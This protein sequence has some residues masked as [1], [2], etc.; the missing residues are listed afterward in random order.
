MPTSDPQGTSAVLNVFLAAGGGTIL[1]LAG[2]FLT[3]LLRGTVPQEKE[4][5]D[6]MATEVKELR[7]EVRTLRSEVS[8]MSGRIEQ[9]IRL[10]AR[11]Y[12]QRE[13]ARLRVNLLEQKYGEPITAWPPDPEEEP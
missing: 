7:V 11:L 4:L 1:T 5:R 9:L 3:G 10:G 12:R 6:G 8:Q 2:A 13:E